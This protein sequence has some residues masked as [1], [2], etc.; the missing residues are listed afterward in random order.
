MYSVILSQA[1][2]TLVTLAEAKAQC[3]VT[4]D[5]DDVLIESLILVASD[6]AQKYSN[7]MLTVGSAMA[8]V[9]SYCKTVQLPY[10]D[11]TGVTELQL[12]GV[13][14]TDYT[15][16]PVTQKVTIGSPYSTA[17]ITFSCGFVSVPPA[18]KHAVLLSISTLY[19]NRDDFVTGLTVASMPITSERL[20]DTV[21]Y[22]VI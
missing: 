14:S 1:P 4:H 17:K 19:N 2:L 22:Y 8:V 12:D 21:R 6:M 3:R 18:V 15:F 7:R 20:L 11:T 9:E 10:G 16:E 13:V 5:F